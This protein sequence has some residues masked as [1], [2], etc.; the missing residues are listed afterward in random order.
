MKGLRIFWVAIAALT[1]AHATANSAALAASKAEQAQDA[2]RIVQETL[3]C[4][5]YGRVA[6][7]TEALRPAI[8]ESPGCEA[9]MWCSGFVYDARRR[10]WL[11]HDE[12]PQ[13][14]EK[15]RRLASYRLARGK[16]PQTIDGQMELARWCTSHKLFDQARAHLTKVLEWDP[17]HPQ[18]RQ[19]LGFRMVNGSWVSEEEMSQAQE[20]VRRAQAALAQWKPR[21][22]KLRQALAQSN[23]RQSDLARQEL[24]AI[25]SPDAVGAVEQVL[26]A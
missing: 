9:A 7:R 16:Y 8:E 14:A 22:E 19:L 21:L 25:D 5:A 24:K 18:A 12:V 13:F 2:A 1:A 15:D 10:E 3:L 26:C 11:R 23:R 4:E 20:R 17:S 6:D